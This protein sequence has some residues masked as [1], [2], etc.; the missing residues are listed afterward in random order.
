MNKV[1]LKQKRNEQDR[2]VSKKKYCKNELLKG[3][4]FDDISM[5]K[6]AYITGANAVLREIEQLVSKF[7]T[8][9]G[10]QYNDLYVRMKDKIRELKGE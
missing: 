9:P 4:S 8:H 5:M 10:Y 1:T 6:P 3:S 7:D 2:R